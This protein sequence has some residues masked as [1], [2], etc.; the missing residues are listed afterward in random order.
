MDAAY[1]TFLD[2]GKN[3]IMDSLVRKAA[4]PKKAAKALSA[5]DAGDPHKVFCSQMISDK[6]S[7][8]DLIEK[9]K[10]FIEQ[11]EAKL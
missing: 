5:E 9:V 8:A 10:K 7:K 4:A 1:K 11:E 2:S 6:P 3:L